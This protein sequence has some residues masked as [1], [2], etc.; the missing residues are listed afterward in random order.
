[1][2]LLEAKISRRL[3][4]GSKGAP[5]DAYP[6]LNP[7]AGGLRPGVVAG[8]VDARCASAFSVAQWPRRVVCRN[9]RCH[10]VCRI[11]SELSGRRA[12]WDSSASRRLEYV[13]AA[14]AQF[15]ALYSDD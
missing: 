11:K 8:S 4:L 10:T 13:S 1:M 3:A 2:R 15:D 14:G 7:D 12:G 5:N 6:S 9:L